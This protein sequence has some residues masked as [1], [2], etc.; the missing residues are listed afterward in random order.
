M[1]QIYFLIVLPNLSSVRSA[2]GHKVKRNTRQKRK[3]PGVKRMEGDY[4]RNNEA[5]VKQFNLHFHPGLNVS[6]YYIR[7]EKKY[8]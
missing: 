7:K 3:Q 6:Y 2:S 4:V 1:H 5:I 8:S